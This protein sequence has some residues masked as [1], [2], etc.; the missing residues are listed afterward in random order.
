MLGVMTAHLFKRSK[1]YSS[2][3]GDGLLTPSQ[4]PACLIGAAL[5]SPGAESRMSWHFQGYLMSLDGICFPSETKLRKI[6]FPLV[7]SSS[8]STTCSSNKEQSLQCNQHQPK[9]KCQH[10]ELE[11]SHTTDDAQRLTV[12][13]QVLFLL[14]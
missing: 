5:P 13:P 7:N 10:V 2:R 14:C 3:R 9:K 11:H 1:I 12:T 8:S 4:D 6:R